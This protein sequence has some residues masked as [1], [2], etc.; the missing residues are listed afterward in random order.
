M[1]R[2]LVWIPVVVS[3]VVVTYA[4]SGDADA[5]KKLEGRWKVKS[6]EKG[7]KPA[8]PGF[9]EAVT[10]IFSGDKLTLHF[11][12]GGKEDKKVSKLKLDAAKKPGHFDVTP[13]DG[14]EKD[15]TMPGIYELK[16]NTLKLCVND[17][18]TE[19]PAT[20]ASPEGSRF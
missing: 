2:R 17:G 8:P 15:K 3:L 12:E 13:T 4:Q 11:K 6:A 7:G 1:Q 20:F 9:T 18:G 10:F 14:P 19:R 16:G 5:L